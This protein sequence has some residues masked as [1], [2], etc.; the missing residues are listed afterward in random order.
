M[1]HD[2][3]AALRLA[4]QAGETAAFVAGGG[5]IYQEALAWV[6]K[7]YLTAVQ[8]T[9]EGDVFFPSLDA[10]EWIEVSRSHHPADDKYAHPYDFVEMTR[11]AHKGHSH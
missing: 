7:L 10:A 4:E 9:V 3:A 1:V 2:L 8:A 5:C 11:V 6:D